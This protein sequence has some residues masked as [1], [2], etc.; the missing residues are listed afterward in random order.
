M[1][2]D[3]KGEADQENKPTRSHSVA[4]RERHVFQSRRGGKPRSITVVCRADLPDMPD[5]G[6]E[7]PAFTPIESRTGPFVS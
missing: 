3:H 2:K 1:C 7:T 5:E 4:H 6:A